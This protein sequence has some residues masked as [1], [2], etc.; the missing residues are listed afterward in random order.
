ME[1][2]PYQPSAAAALRQTKRGRRNDV[3]AGTIVGTVLSV[4][5]AGSGDLVM[6]L[7]QIPPQP[8]CVCRALL[9]AVAWIGTIWLGCRIRTRRHTHELSD[10]AES[11]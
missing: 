8:D 4:L 6:H 10:E 1:Q 5:V 9:L 11:E 7:I 3:I 2:N